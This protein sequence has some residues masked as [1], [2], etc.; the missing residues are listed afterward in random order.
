MASML[1]D[2][3]QYL[4]GLLHSHPLWLDK[5]LFDLQQFDFS[6]IQN[7]TIL[8]E[9]IAIIRINPNEVLGKRIEHYFETLIRFNKRYS[10]ILKNQQIFKQKITL[11]ELDYIIQ[12]TYKDLLIHL[13]L[14][15]KFYLYDPD[16]TSELSRWIGPNRKDSFLEKIDKLTFKQFPLLYKEETQSLLLDHEIEPQ[17][18]LQQV[19]FLGNLFIPYYLKTKKYNSINPK[20][21]AGYWISFNDFLTND[22][23]N[24]AYYIPQKKDWI[25]APKFSK[26]WKSYN[27]ILPEVSTSI[28]AEKSP[29]L[30]VK[31]NEDSFAKIFVVWW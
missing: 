29:L 21:I 12:D 27:E 31:Y 4:Y 15:Y 13:E 20:A 11:G 19:C 16:I 28:K 9:S 1:F 18:C 26:T 24:L 10:I 3:K 30:W 7:S 22:F 17:D 8:Q 23:K 5:K 14:V 25:I 6:S 2:Q